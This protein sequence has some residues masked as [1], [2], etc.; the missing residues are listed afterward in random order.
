MVPVSA[1]T[2]TNTG[3]APQYRAPR[4]PSPGSCSRPRGPRRPARRPARQAPGAGRPYSCSRRSR[5]AWPVSALNPL[6]ERGAA[7][8]LTGQ[9]AG[10]EAPRRPP[11][12]SA[13]STDGRVRGIGRRRRVGQVFHGV[14]M[15]KAI[16]TSGDDPDAAGPHRRSRA[17]R[18]GRVAARFT[19]LLDPCRCSRFPP[20]TRL[21]LAT[22]L[23]GTST[24][25]CSTSCVGMVLTPP[26]FLLYR[27]FVWSGGSGRSVWAGAVLVLADRHGGRAR[28]QR[29]H[30]RGRRCRSTPTNR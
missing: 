27:W 6:L 26:S 21:L 20:A 13:S 22:A 15:R 28:V 18:R 7:R 12:S 17:G 11:P 9:P 5:D 10:V 25:A 16:T 4:A 3:V 1:R 14:M 30:R 19:P 29:V 23:L 24:P 2:S 8:A